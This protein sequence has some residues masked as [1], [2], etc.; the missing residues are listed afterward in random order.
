MD[1][2]PSPVSATDAPCKLCRDPVT[3]TQNE[4]L[5]QT[6]ALGSERPGIPAP[7]PTAFP[8]PSCVSLGK[9]YNLSEAVAVS[10]KMGE[11]R[12]PLEGDCED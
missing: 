4:A 11:M 9:L 12:S 7:Q 8:F 10:L 2:V 1:L 5:G 3:W 6:R